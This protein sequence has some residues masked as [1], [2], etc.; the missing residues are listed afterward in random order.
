MVFIRKLVNT[1][2]GRKLLFTCIGHG[3]APVYSDLE[4]INVIKQIQRL[5][6]IV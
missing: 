6:P 2:V 5:G 1:L 3:K 4:Q